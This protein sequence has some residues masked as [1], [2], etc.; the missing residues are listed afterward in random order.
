MEEHIRSLF[1]GKYC[2]L[3]RTNYYGLKITDQVLKVVGR[4]I[5]KIVSKF[6][7]IDDMQFGFMYGCGTTDVIF[8]VTKLEERFLDKNE[9]LC[10]H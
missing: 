3:D 8:I 1:E 10:F 2:A 4:V 6:I 5:E 7:I 9:K